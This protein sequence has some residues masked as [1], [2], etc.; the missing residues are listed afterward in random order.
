[1][2]RTELL[3]RFAG[4]AQA[5]DSSPRLAVTGQQGVG[6]TTFAIELAHRI[7]P[8]FDVCLFYP[9]DATQAG[10][11]VSAGQVAGHFLRK[12]KV[13]ADEIPADDVERFL[14]LAELL[15]DR[16]V[17]LL[18]DDV[19]DAAQLAPFVQYVAADAFIVTSRNQMPVLAASGFRPVE[20]EMFD[21]HSSGLL[22]RHIIPESPEVNDELVRRLHRWSGGLPLA[23]SLMAARL[24]QTEITVDDFE[25]LL[26]DPPERDSA[27][28]MAVESMFQELELEQARQCAILALIPGTHFDPVTAA[29]ALGVSES[30][31]RQVLRG[32]RD[33]HLLLPPEDDR[34]G[35]HDMLR[36]FA[37]DRALALLSDTER[38]DIASRV[39]EHRWLRVVALDKSIS[40]RPVPEPVAQWYAGIEPAFTGQ[41]GVRAA[42][43]EF[44]RE[45]RNF[46][47]AADEARKLPNSEL[48][49]L[50]P[51]G[52]WAYSF[53]TA[54]H[55]EIVEILDEA[56]GASVDAIRRWF[57][58]RDKAASCHGMRDNA[59]TSEAIRQASQLDFP[60]GKQSLHDWY[61]NA[62]EGQGDYEGALGQFELSRAAIPAMADP[63]Q[64]ERA[65]ALLDMHVGR[66]LAKQD[67]F[68]EAG[69]VLF[70]AHHY[71][72]AR[73]AESVNRARA[74]AW[75]GKITLD[76]VTAHELL[77]D[78]L[79]V[80]MELD[81]LDLAIE[82]CTS[83]AERA[84]SAS[85]HEDAQHYRQLV[86]ELAR[87]RKRFDD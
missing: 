20:L 74:G 8:D 82:V 50:F 27:G 75:L 66:V 68:T 25:V 79:A 26:A 33:A 2:D 59:A 73:E 10:R 84:E 3:D 46:V 56:L 61:G 45:W 11:M 60:Q 83:L 24:S 17:L 65:A 42:F 63:A 39:I 69:Q 37:L 15:D 38:Q 40:N 81:M 85:G 87:K 1:M 53:Q 58:L 77:A 62:L 32:L 30:V 5:G 44:D 16:R 29:V 23:L 57:L 13:S 9:V 52:L 4:E 43:E 34:Y 51:L 14:T 70:Q 48:G 21:V 55:A 71:F 76:Y 64:Q 72:A 36:R 19:Q 47:A 54:R 12:L 78:A 7:K 67:R 35:F 80:F 28:A 86:E 6:K 18:L 41:E 31:A 49:S 22:V